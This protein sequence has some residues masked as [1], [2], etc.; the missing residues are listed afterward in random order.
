MKEVPLFGTISNPCYVILYNLHPELRLQDLRR[1]PRR[2]LQSS[3]TRSR[4]VM[5]AGVGKLGDVGNYKY[6]YIYIL[7]VGIDISLAFLVENE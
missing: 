6:I 5:H 7:E 4:K 1:H 2:L 3:L